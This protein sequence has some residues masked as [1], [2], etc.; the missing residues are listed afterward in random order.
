[1]TKIADASFAEHK[2][3]MFRRGVVHSAGHELM[4]A[5]SKLARAG[6]E[7]RV[8]HKISSLCRYIAKQP[9]LPV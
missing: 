3:G 7:M 8:L 6:I 4:P 2:V 5:H 1:M 9:A